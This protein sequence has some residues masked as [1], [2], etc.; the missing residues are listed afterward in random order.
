MLLNTMRIEDTDPEY[1][2]RRSLHQF[3]NEKQIPEMKRKL[4]DLN[5]QM[6]GF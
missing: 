2:I 3:Q 4:A 6:K 1:V 5:E